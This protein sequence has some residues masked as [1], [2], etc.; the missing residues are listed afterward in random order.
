MTF[1]EAVR[2][3]LS[4]FADGNGRATRS[5]FWYFY[6]FYI[7]VW[8]AVQVIDIPI[9]TMAS[10]ALIIP[11]IAA[12]VRRMHD[13]DK[14]GWFV[15][16]PIYN[17]ILLATPGTVGPNRYGPDPADPGNWAP[18]TIANAGQGFP[19][20]PNPESD[21]Q[22]EYWG[23]P[24]PYSPTQKTRYPGWL[25]WALLAASPIFAFSPFIIGGIG[26]QLTCEGGLAAANEGNC[27]WAA[28]PWAM[29]MTI[30][31]GI[32]MAVVGLVMGIISAFRKG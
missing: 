18:P 24:T 25:G 32:L 21:L 11:N 15:L 31:G 7:V 23:A 6:L 3:C 5:E 30:P 17:L 1:T 4:K 26:A 19:N 10:L 9:L 27:G 12:S 20:F 22:D 28:L 16:I 14:S 2:T 13:I 29:I 8:V